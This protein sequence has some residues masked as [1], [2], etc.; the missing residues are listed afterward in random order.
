MLSLRFLVVF[1]IC[2]HNYPSLRNQSLVEMFLFFLFL[3]LASGLVSVASIFSIIRRSTQS[4]FVRPRNIVFEWMMW[5]YLVLVCLLLWSLRLPFV[6]NLYIHIPHLNGLSL[7]C[8]LW[9]IKRFA[10][11]EN[12]LLHSIHLYG[13]VPVWMCMCPRSLHKR[14]K[15]LSHPW[16]IQQNLPSP[17]FYPSSLFTEAFWIFFPKLCSILFITF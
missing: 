4:A 13:C 14:E 7:V 2:Y 5:T 1:F 10:L 12:Y 6:V 17:A 9:W 3:T 8:T 15:D 16:Y 11:S